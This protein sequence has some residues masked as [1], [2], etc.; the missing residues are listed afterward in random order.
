MIKPEILN[1]KQL[2]IRESIA[3]A[4]H[5]DNFEKIDIYRSINGMNIIVEYKG[6]TVVWSVKDMAEKSIEIIDG[7]NQE[8][9]QCTLL[10][11]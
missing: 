9:E 10:C 6:K 3:T 1:G 5:S 8:E 7:K 11:F 2:I 4:T